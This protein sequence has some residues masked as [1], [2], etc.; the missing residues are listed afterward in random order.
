MDEE[1]ISKHNMP[2][3]IHSM[4]EE[5]VIEINS[6]YSEEE[7]EEEEEENSSVRGAEHCDETD[8]MQP[9]TAQQNPSTEDQNNVCPQATK[10]AK[11]SSP[12]KIGRDLAGKVNFIGLEP[13]DESPSSAELENEEPSGLENIKIVNVCTLAHDFEE[14]TTEDMGIMD[15]NSKQAM[16]PEEGIPQDSVSPTTPNMIIVQEHRSQS[17]LSVMLV[18]KFCHQLFPTHEALYYHARHHRNIEDE[19]S[20]NKHFHQQVPVEKSQGNEMKNESPVQQSVRESVQKKRKSDEQDTS[21]Q[22]P[23][24]KMKRK[25]QGL[26]VEEN[27][28][29]K[30]GKIFMKDYQYK[31]HILLCK[32]KTSKMATCFE[33]NKMI[34]AHEEYE[35]ALKYHNV[36]CQIC[37]H[38]LMQESRLKSHMKLVHKISNDEKVKKSTERKN[39]FLV[40]EQAYYRTCSCGKACGSYEEYQEH[41]KKHRADR[42]T[43]MVPKEEENEKPEDEEKTEQNQNDSVEIK[44]EKCGKIFLSS[45]HLESHLKRCSATAVKMMLCDI[46]EKLVPMDEHREH[47]YSHRIACELCGKI[48]MGERHLQRHHCLAKQ[49]M[50]E[51]AARKEKKTTLESFVSERSKTLKMEKLR[52]SILL[53][54][55]LKRKL[56]AEQEEFLLMEM[57]GKK[58]ESQNLSSEVTD[59]EVVKDPVVSD[60][61]KATSVVEKSAIIPVQCKNDE[62]DRNDIFDSISSKEEKEK[63]KTVIAAAL[64]CSQSESNPEKDDSHVSFRVGSEGSNT[65]KNVNKQT[66]IKKGGKRKRKKYKRGKLLGQRRKQR[67]REEKEEVHEGQDIV[68]LALAVMERKCDEIDGCNVL[69]AAESHSQES[70]AGEEQSV[71]KTIRINPSPND[72]SKGAKRLSQESENEGE[73]NAKTHEDVQN[74]ASKSSLEENIVNSEE[75]KV[76]YVE[77]LKESGIPTSEPIVNSSMIKVNWVIKSHLDDWLM[78]ASQSNQNPQ[79]WICRHCGKQLKTREEGLNHMIEYHPANKTTKEIVKELNRS[80]NYIY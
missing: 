79:A 73:E 65:E 58:L 40:V 18:C 39:V 42:K 62:D 13:A 59:R 55:N 38:N 11:V 27:K 49:K 44:C 29:E 30:C 10:T 46:C 80:R 77:I 75:S 24:K 3:T 66:D 45:Y 54:K 25:S 1:S 32:G 22:K 57:N 28:C 36:V 17:T 16:R 43:E 78:P 4:G 34:P 2:K 15:P 68:A 70:A 76:T 53:A 64:S 33:C 8:S 12:I 56:T 50:K 60:V 31:T 37:G 71:K 35:H 20:V 41:K 63:D 52:K 61:E 19:H 47:V 6:D 7:G 51:E 69:M 21:E 67:I 9:C 14:D 72:I 23:M 48:C 74:S 26:A 5:F